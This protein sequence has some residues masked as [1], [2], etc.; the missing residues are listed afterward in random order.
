M[1][2]HRGMSRRDLIRTLAL[3]A[4]ALT[5]AGYAREDAPA[6]GE[7]GP[8]PKL[9]P[10]ASLGG[11]RVFP[12][13]NPWNAD[14]SGAPA[15]PDSDA[16]VAG[17]GPDRPL[18]PGF[19]TVYR[20]A[21]SGIPYVVVPGA[22]P[23][24]AV[25]FQYPGKSDPGP[26]PIPADAPVEGGPDSRGDRHVLVLD[27]DN[28]KL[29]ELFAARKDAQGWKAGSGAIFDLTSNAL[30]PAGWTSA[31]AAG[32]PVFPGLVRYDE[33]HEQKA[34]RHA[35]RFT[36]RRTRRAYV[37]PARHFASRANDPRLP[38]MG[39][40]VRLKASYDI[41]GFSP[42]VQVILTGL[43]KYGMF[44]ADNGGD[45]FLSGAPDPRWDDQDL[46]TLKRVRGRDFEVVLMGQPVTR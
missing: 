34:I 36:V 38:P 43:K 24:V 9:G 46:H 42:A 23:R 22:Q 15:D 16:L 26:Y 19:G 40:R 6:A 14:A 13:D 18:H 33:V 30:R 37:R 2:E 1:S 5:L 44:L 41:S 17:I 11:K 39:M 4:G 3:S 21:P 27:R 25:R 31:D 29:Y 10:N 32:L 8:G 35:L 20:G 12:P 28:W 45:W 7:S